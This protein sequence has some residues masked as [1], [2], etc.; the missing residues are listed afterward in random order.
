MMSTFSKNLK[1]LRI[2]KNMTQEQAANAL[3]VSTQT[4]SRWE[5]NTTLPDVTILPEIAKLYCVTID[6]LYKDTAVAYE[7]YAQRLLSIYEQTRKTHD[8][9]RA[10]ME[11]RRLLKDGT[12]TTKDIYS[13]GVLYQYLMENSRDFALSMF[14]KVIAKGPDINEETYWKA[15]RQRIYFLSLIGRADEAVAEQE[16]QI[17]KSTNVQE[18]I[19]LIAAYQHAGRHNNAVSWMEKALHEY[20]DNYVLLIYCGDIYRSLKQYDKAFDCYKRALN[21]DS[22]YLDA[23]YSMGFCYEE[24]GEYEKAYNT[25]CELCDILEQRGFESEINFP[26]MLAQKCKSKIASK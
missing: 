22:S 2:A 5:C 10:D 24:L 19:S 1:K 14:D 23:R 11:F 25:W 3:G 7:N 6:D 21:T 12:A 9:L 17:K 16:E 15:K 4:V 20:S 13:Y 18:I 26:K 8:F